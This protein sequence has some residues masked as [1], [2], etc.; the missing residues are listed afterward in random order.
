MRKTPY[1]YL[2]SAICSA[3]FR[4]HGFEVSLVACDGRLPALSGRGT[5][6]IGRRL[7]I[8]GRVARC[9][10]GVSRNGQLLIG[11]RVF[12]NQG[13]VIAVRESIEIGVVA[14]R[15]VVRGSL[16]PRLKT[17]VSPGARDLDT[18]SARCRSPL[19]VND[20]KSVTSRSMSGVLKVCAGQSDLC[21]L[22]PQVKCLT[23]KSQLVTLYGLTGRSAAARDA[24]TTVATPT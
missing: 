3:L 14:A 11:D 7:V 16:P 20:N 8:R 2:K 22:L 4:I 19:V 18:R 9:E 17:H 24:V 21:R 23:L 10:I 5:A 6:R 12:S 13:V 1:L 15:S